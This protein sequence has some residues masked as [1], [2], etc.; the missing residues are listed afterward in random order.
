MVVGLGGLWLGLLAV[1]LAIRA[2]GGWADGGLLAVWVVSGVGGWRFGAVRDLGGWRCGR[3][4]VWAVGG[5]QLVVCGGGLSGLA[6]WG[7]FRGWRFKRLA[8]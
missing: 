8:V 2:V 1:W 6:G 3:L 7:G 5:L 4:A